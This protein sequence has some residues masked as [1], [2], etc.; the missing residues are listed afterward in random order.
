MPGFDVDARTLCASM[1]SQLEL[2]NLAYVRILCRYDVEGL[3]GEDYAKAKNIV[4][5]E[6]MVDIC[7]DETFPASAGAHTVLAAH[8][9]SSC[10]CKAHARRLPLQPST[11]SA[12]SSAKA[13]WTRSASI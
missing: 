13:I 9:V 5:S 6:P 3:S 7:Y 10:C 1:K 2:D 12:A 4:F 11:C 8:S